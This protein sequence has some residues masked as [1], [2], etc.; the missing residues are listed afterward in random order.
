MSDAAQVSRDGVMQARKEHHP[1]YELLYTLLEAS[2]ANSDLRP[3]DADRLRNNLAPL[4]GPAIARLDV[5]REARIALTWALLENGRG[6]DALRAARVNVEQARKLSGQGSLEYAADLDYLAFELGR[7]G[8]KEE[9]EQ[10]LVEL[11]R[12]ALAF[13]LLRDWFSAA[14]TQ[15][16][17]LQRLAGNFEEVNLL[18]SEAA[19]SQAY[20][21]AFPKD[22]LQSFNEIIKEFNGRFTTVNPR[23]IDMTMAQ[24]AMAIAEQASGK[25]ALTLIDRVA[26]FVQW[27]PEP[28]RRLVADWRIRE[29]ARLT[30]PD[31]DASVQAILTASY[32]N[33]PEVLERAETLIRSTRG[34]DSIELENVLLR[35]IVFLPPGQF[36]SALAIRRTLLQLKMTI[37]GE[38]SQDVAEEYARTA[39]FCDQAGHPDEGRPLWLAFIDTSRKWTGS[40]G[41]QHAWNMSRAAISLAQHNDFKQAIAWNDEAVEA[42]KYDPNSSQE[43]LKVRG[44]I[45]ELQRKASDQ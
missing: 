6:A 26:Q 23:P 3:Q 36:A 15:R 9:A 22:M 1:F 27:N 25:G 39:D 14:L 43:M 2:I 29:V 11:E 21:P 45:L 32:P 20:G 7:Q 37:Y 40:S 10:T 41:W 28:D 35:K 31:S 34:V 24:K 16:A 5:T 18:S 8:Q 19:R 17:E 4:I 38:Q 42:A 44:Q 33:R 30:G 13:P 12:V